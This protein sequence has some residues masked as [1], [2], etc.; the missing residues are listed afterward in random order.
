M[1]SLLGL[2]ALARYERHTIEVILDRVKVSADKRG[3]LTE[4]VEQGFKLGKGQCSVAR[5]SAV[6]TFSSSLSCRICG[7]DVVE[8]EPRLFSFNSP[9]GACPQCDGIGQDRD[10]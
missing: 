7:V 3:R 10:V 9:H 6:E 2:C 8:L 5:G 4:A 1:R